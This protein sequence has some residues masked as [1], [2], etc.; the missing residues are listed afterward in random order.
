MVN[1]DSHALGLIAIHAAERQQSI[2]LKEVV[3]VRLLLIHFVLKVVHHFF[4][5]ALGLKQ[6][7]LLLL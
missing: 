1:D 6:G 7:V 3:D 2:L 4:V 5:P